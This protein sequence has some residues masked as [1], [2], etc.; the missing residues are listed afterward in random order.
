MLAVMVQSVLALA[1]EM[2]RPKAMSAW[3][4]TASLHPMLVVLGAMAAYRAQTRVLALL[5]LLSVGACSSNN[6]LFKRSSTSPGSTGI[7]QIKPGVFVNK[8]ATSAAELQAQFPQL[9]ALIA[10]GRISS[11]EARSYIRTVKKRLQL[12]NPDQTRG[13]DH[14]LTTGVVE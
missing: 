7:E 6:Q 13:F 1:Y 8:T 11:E 12:P 9:K 10:E 2:G 4:N 5:A 14:F 3:A